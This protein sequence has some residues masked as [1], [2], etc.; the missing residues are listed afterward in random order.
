MNKRVNSFVFTLPII[1][2]L[3]VLILN[4]IYLKNQES[5]IV[6]NLKEITTS[7]INCVQ[8]L[9]QNYKVNKFHIFYLKLNK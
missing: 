8:Q 9:F 4:R 2:L 7:F 1:L 3:P 6:W 5:L